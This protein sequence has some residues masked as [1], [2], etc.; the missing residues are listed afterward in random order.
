MAEKVQVSLRQVNWIWKDHLI[1]AS[2]EVL[3]PQAESSWE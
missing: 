1:E 3:G 2:L